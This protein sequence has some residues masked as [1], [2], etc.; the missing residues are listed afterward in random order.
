[1]EPAGF[2]LKRSNQSFEFGYATFYEI[3][4]FNET[5]LDHVEKFLD[6]LPKSKLPEPY[7]NVKNDFVA[8]RSIV[9]AN[10]QNFNKFKE[11][12]RAAACKKEITNKEETLKAILAAEN[13]FKKPSTELR[14][15]FDKFNDSLDDFFCKFSVGVQEKCEDEKKH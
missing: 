15:A 7:E 1:V 3:L 14:D 5:Y 8:I 11:A 12:F 4:N 2:E 9:P 13:K 6:E 10:S